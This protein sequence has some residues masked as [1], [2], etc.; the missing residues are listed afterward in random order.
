[1]EDLYNEIPIASTIVG[2]VDINNT[3]QTYRNVS[4]E[5]NFYEFRSIVERKP[6]LF[7]VGY[8][9]DTQNLMAQIL[10]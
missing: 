1:M 7:N 4:H 6:E 2:Y 3:A 9:Y 10:W 8:F 5:Y